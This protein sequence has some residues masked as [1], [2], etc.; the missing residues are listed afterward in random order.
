MTLVFSYS[1]RLTTTDSGYSNYY[2]GKSKVPLQ[3]RPMI[4]AL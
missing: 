4:I 3:L 1:H 2:T